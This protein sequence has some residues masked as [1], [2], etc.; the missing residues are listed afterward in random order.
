MP[1]FKK[2]TTP[3]TVEIRLWSVAPRGLKNSTDE[4]SKHHSKRRHRSRAIS[5]TTKT[6]PELRHL[7]E[8]MRPNNRASDEGVGNM[9]GGAA[10]DNR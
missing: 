2:Q 9:T 4:A 3:I 6:K 5:H 1:S 7:E 10:W 8:Q